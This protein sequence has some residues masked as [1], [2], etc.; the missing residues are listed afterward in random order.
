MTTQTIQCTHPLVSL[1]V[2]PRPCCPTLQLQTNACF[3]VLNTCSMKPICIQRCTTHCIQLQQRLPWPTL[4]EPPHLRQLH[5]LVMAVALVLV[6]ELE[7]ERAQALELERVQ[8]L[9]RMVAHV[10]RPH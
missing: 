8:V 1:Y 6:L 2:F 9:Q 4:W 3:A 5:L 7:L 10:K